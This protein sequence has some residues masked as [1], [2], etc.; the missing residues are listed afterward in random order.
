MARTR[1]HLFDRLQTRLTVLY[2]GLFATALL[3]VSLAVFGAVSSSAGRAVRAEL[4]AGGTVFD[5]LWALRSQVFVVEQH[6]PYPDL[7]GRDREPTTWHLLVRQ[8]GRLVG[9]ARVLDDG[10]WARIG[11]L[12]VAADARGRFSW[13]LEQRIAEWLEQTMPAQLSSAPA[14]RD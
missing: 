8:D 4:T 3:V 6:S 9:Y 1:F 12:V 13:W 7:D 11:R 5:R 2:A 14:A 10:D